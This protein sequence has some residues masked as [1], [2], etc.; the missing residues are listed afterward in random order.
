M[1]RLQLQKEHFERSVAPAVTRV[2]V[3]PVITATLRLSPLQA[4]NVLVSSR[5]SARF[6]EGMKQD[7]ET[8]KARQAEGHM[9]LDEIQ[10]AN[11]LRDRITRLQSSYAPS[12]RNRVSVS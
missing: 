12:L 11:R 5:V 7:L 2:P 6:V 9:L 8:H 3:S 1:D 4:V 10:R